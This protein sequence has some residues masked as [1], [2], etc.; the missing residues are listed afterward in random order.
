ML[1]G[2]IARFRN[3]IRPVFPMVAE[4]Q[5]KNNS[6]NMQFLYNIY[7]QR[8]FEEEDSLVYGDRL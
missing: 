1:D 5:R 7:E 6:L 8:K 3:P 4:I 2:V